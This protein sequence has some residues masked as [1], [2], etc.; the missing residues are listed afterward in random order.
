MATEAQDDKLKPCPFCRKE[1]TVVVRKTDDGY[2]IYCYVI[3]NRKRGGC[4]SSSG[5]RDDREGAIRA[6]NERIES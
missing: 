4:G 6:W 1:G 2:G 5:Y 3:C